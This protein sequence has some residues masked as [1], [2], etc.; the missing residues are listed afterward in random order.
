LAKHGLTLEEA[1]FYSDSITDLPLLE[2]VGQP[3]AVNPDMRLA[4]EAKRR[5]WKIDR[6]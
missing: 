5:G 4:R 3:V 2:C 6:W 1:T